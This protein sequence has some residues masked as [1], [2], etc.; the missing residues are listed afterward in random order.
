M[1]LMKAGDTMDPRVIL[2]YG[3]DTFYTKLKMNKVIKRFDLDEYHVTHYDLDETLLQDAVTDAMTIPFMSEMKV[4]VCHNARFLGKEKLKKALP[5]D[6]G[7]LGAYLQNPPDETLLIVTAPVKQLDD[8]HALVKQF[9]KHEVVECK[10]KSSQDLVAWARRQ[11]GQ[12]AINIDE[13]AL[14]AFIKRVEHSTEFA[15]L[16]MRKLLLYVDEGKHIDVATIEKVVTKNVE[17]NVFEITNALLKKDARRALEVYRD[18]ITHSEDPLRILNIIVMKYR[19]MLHARTL[20]DQGKSQADI[21]AHYNVSSGRAYYMVQNAKSAS[22]ERIQKHLRELEK[23]DY[24]IKS[25]RV[26]KKVALE[27]FILHT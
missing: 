7:M 8:K 17:D 14:R 13:D 18:L 20:L 5:H 16:E 12:H 24:H 2:F 10:L 6:E 9:R 4:V 27:L 21:Q 3:E 26:D 15:Y 22:M 19:E 25:G 1:G 11:F 23:L